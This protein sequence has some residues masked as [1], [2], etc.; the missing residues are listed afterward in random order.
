[1]KERPGN[2]STFNIEHSTFNIPFLRTFN[3]AKIPA[4]RPLCYD[5]RNVY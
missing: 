5:P 3:L 4:H 1:M 2:H